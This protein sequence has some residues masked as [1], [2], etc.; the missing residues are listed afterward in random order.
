MSGLPPKPE[1]GEISPTGSPSRP[2]PA[3][4]PGP[5]RYH[6]N[7]RATAAPMAPPAAYARSRASFDPGM[8]QRETRYRD[9]YAEWERKYGRE[10]YAQRQWDREPPVASAMYRERV[11]DRRM[12]GGRYRERSRSPPPARCKL[13]HQ[14]SKGTY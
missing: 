9:Q 6:I 7:S 13:R 1:P 12:G 10:Y 5:G 3:P 2:S 4:S 11:P 8:E 14:V